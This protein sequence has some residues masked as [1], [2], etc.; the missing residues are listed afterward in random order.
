MPRWRRSRFLQRAARTSLLALVVCCAAVAVSTSSAGVVASITAFTVDGQPGSYVGDGQS[1]VFTPQNESF[2]A[3]QYGDGFQE[4]VN[5]DHFYCALVTPPTG[6]QFVVGTTYQTSRMHT[7]TT[8]G[9]DVFGDGA[10]CNESHGT[11]TIHELSLATDPMVIAASYQVYCDAAPTPV[12]GELRF[13]STVGYTAASVSPSALH[14][15]SILVGDVSAPQTVTISNAGTQSLTLGSAAITGT[16]AGDFGLGSDAC[17]G[18]TLAAGASCSTSVTFAPSDVEQG[19]AILTFSDNTAAGGRE[20]AL[21][22]TGIKLKGSLTIA[23]SR[24]PITFGQSVKVTATLATASTNRTVSIYRRA[25][26]T[27]APVLVGSGTVDANGKFSLTLK[28]SKDTAYLAK[29]A[30][31][32]THEATTSKQVTV[33]VRLIMHAQAKGAYATRSG[34]HLYH[35]TTRCGSAGRGCPHFLVWASPLHPGGRFSLVLQRHTASGWSTVLRSTGSFRAT[36]KQ[37]IYIIYRSS[38]VRGQSLRIH[39]AMATHNDHLGDTSPWVKFRI[40]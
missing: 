25:P 27:S 24:R 40:T 5:G 6:E 34:Y 13:N 18:A 11:L 20:I 33:N 16:N 4:C 14:F 9:L 8:A 23:A 21:N 31:D 38:V 39:F 32:A 29:W 12:S 35:Y 17:S 28:P 19:T 7:D 26:P 2:T 37:T 22:G 15:G 3:N 36:G 30:G 10:G 1:Y